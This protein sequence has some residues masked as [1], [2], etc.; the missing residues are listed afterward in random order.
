MQ[1]PGQQTFYLEAAV[2]LLQC[3]YKTWI[4]RSTALHF[5][6]IQYV[7]F[8]AGQNQTKM[9][10][11]RMFFNKGASL[12]CS[13]RTPVMLLSSVIIT[14]IDYFPIPIIHSVCPQN[15]A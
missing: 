11:E 5:N 2:C 13:I 12:N 8:F 1:H 9:N 10:N 4:N 7:L 6:V 14:G 3:C 15:L